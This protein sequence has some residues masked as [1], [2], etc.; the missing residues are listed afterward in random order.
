MN[1]RPPFDPET[2]RA[3]DV[4]YLAPAISMGVISMVRQTSPS[5]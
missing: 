4:P 3:V 1:A 2:G 5:L